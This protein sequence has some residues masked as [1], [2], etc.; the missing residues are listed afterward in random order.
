[1]LP[2]KNRKSDRVLSF[3]S[4]LRFLLGNDRFFSVGFPFGSFRHRFHS[5]F[6]DTSIKKNPREF[7]RKIAAPA[8]PAAS[9]RQARPT[10]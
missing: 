1:M 10:S 8:Q 5:S 2:R 7:Q 4:F 6:L 3:A 9:H